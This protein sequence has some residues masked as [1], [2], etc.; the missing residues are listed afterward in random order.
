[1]ATYFFVSAFMVGWATYIAWTCNKRLI[2][3][4]KNIA[5]SDGLLIILHY[6]HCL[7][8]IIE[9]GTKDVLSDIEQKLLDKAKDIAASYESKY[10][11][12]THLNKPQ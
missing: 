1:M 11:I 12:N 4:S 2:Q 3:L 6:H 10:Q 9:L 7:R 8:I 5:V